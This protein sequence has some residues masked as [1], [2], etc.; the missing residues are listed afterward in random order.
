VPLDAVFKRGVLAASLVV[1]VLSQHREARAGLGP[2]EDR[3]GPRGCSPTWQVET[4]RPFTLGLYATAVSARSATDAWLVGGSFDQHGERALIEHWNGTGWRAIPNPG[5]GTLTA[6]AALS[7]ADAWAVGYSGGQSRPLVEHWDGSRWS[8][9][10][11]PKIGTSEVA[12][13]GVDGSSSNDIWAVGLY[14][15][16]GDLAD[17]TLIEHWDGSTWTV[18]LSPN[19]GTGANLL[20]G[21][22]ALSPTE[23]WAVGISYPSQGGAPR[24]LTMRWNGSV[25]ALVNAPNPGDVINYLKSVVAISVT[26]AWAVG[27]TIDSSLPYEVPFILHWD[28]ASWA[29]VPSP[30]L[31][32]FTLQSVSAVGPDD[33]WAAGGN[34]SGGNL[35]EHWESSTWVVVPVPQPSSQD[36]LTSISALPTGE[37]WASGIDVQPSTDR[38]VPLAIHACQA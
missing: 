12:L 5:R 16:T 4:T 9:V 15:N 11:T 30:V 36:Y 29:E 35:V 10:R 25:W 17:R 22:S 20:Y 13:Y 34:L 32:E 8:G 7:D 33:V 14:A 2:P 24:V 38:I 37:L 6:A 21:V 18:I 31:Q 27:V 3:T 23:A 28:G 1:C 19:V 26:D